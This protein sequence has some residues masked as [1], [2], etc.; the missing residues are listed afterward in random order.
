MTQQCCDASNHLKDMNI[1]SIPD[2]LLVYTG[3]ENKVVFARSIV[4]MSFA[5]D[6]MSHLTEHKY[7]SVNGSLVF[8][9]FTSFRT[10]TMSLVSEKILTDSGQMYCINKITNIA[11]QDDDEVC[12]FIGVLE[13]KIRLGIVD[14]AEIT[15]NDMKYVSVP[16][17]DVTMTKSVQ[18]LLKF[19]RCEFGINVVYKKKDGNR[20]RRS[21]LFPRMMFNIEN[22]SH[23]GLYSII[24]MKPCP[25][26]VLASAAHKTVF[27]VDNGACEIRVNLKEFLAQ[28]HTA[29]E[30]ERLRL[31][32]IPIMKSMEAGDV[33]KQMIEFATPNGIMMF[34]VVMI[35]IG[36]S[37]IAVTF[38]K[39]DE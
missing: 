30:M 23:N 6:Y 12:E 8:R 19:L 10:A 37:C 26:Y 32:V 4:H 21:I 27:G 24:T 28:Y 29:S 34:Q 14:Y 5:F 7:C 35:N 15:R 36:R 18:N 17:S 38:S 2:P 3:C 31:E 39:K 9:H 1:L 20:T 22:I 16:N 13:A 33:V 25:T 11:W